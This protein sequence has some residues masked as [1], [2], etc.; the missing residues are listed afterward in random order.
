MTIKELKEIITHLPDETL[1]QVE[2]EDVCEVKFVSI[3]LRKDGS[4]RFVL[5][6]LE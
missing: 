4:K 5:S 2:Q 6:A 3:V 1:I